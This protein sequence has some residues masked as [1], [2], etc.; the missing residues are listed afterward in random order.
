VHR[1]GLPELEDRGVLQGHR[2][3]GGSSGI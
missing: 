2:R 3:F 1:D